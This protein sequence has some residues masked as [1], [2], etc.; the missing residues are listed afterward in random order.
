MRKVRAE[1]PHV[2]E[3]VGYVPSTGRMLLVALKFVP[4][5]SAWSG[6]DECWVRTAHPYGDGT[7]GRKLARG[8]LIELR[9]ELTSIR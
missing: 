4:A 2:R 8:L 1:E 3:I 9:L 6:R 5:S 7:L